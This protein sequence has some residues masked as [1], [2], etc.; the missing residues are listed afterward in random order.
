LHPAHPA[1]SVS[2]LI[3]AHP[4]SKYFFVGKIGK[5]QVIDYAARKGVTPEKIER[6]LATDLNYL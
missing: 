6:W 3:F 5:D 4:Q 2:G 1:A